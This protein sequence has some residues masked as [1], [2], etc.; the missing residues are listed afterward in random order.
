MSNTPA[1]RIPLL[2]G[3]AVDALLCGGV[4]LLAL[5]VRAWRLGDQS[6]WYDEWIT[7]RA[8]DVSGLAA[9]LR[10][11]GELDWSFVPA[12]HVL[13]YAWSEL[14]SKSDTGL[15]WLSVLLSMAAF[16]PLYALSLRL[17]GRW[18][19]A[20]ATLVF[21]LA[22]YQVFQAQSI[23]NYPLAI[24]ATIAGMYFLW[25]ATRPE[26]ARGWWMANV[27]ANGLLLW[28]HAFG[29]FLFAVQG[30]YLLLF[31]RSPVRRWFIWG[32]AHAG[33]VLSVA[34]WQ[35]TLPGNQHYPDVPP[36]P[37]SQVY[38]LL[39][40]H[41]THPFDWVDYNLPADNAREVLSPLGAWFSARNEANAFLSPRMRLGAWLFRFTALL[42]A[43]YLVSSLWRAWHDVTER[44]RLYLTAAWTLIP[45]A[46]LMALAWGLHR[47]VLVERYM[48]FAYIGLYVALGAAVARL[49][50]VWLRAGA[51][52]LLVFL[53]GAQAL[54]MQVIPLRHDYLGAARV[55]QRHAHPGEPVI[56]LKQNAAVLF[57]HNLH[58]TDHQVE[59]VTDYDTLLRRVSEELDAHGRVWV[60][61]EAVPAQVGYADIEAG[62]GERLIETFQSN[63]WA[64]SC[65]VFGGM[66]NVW[67]FKV[68]EGDGGT[69]QSE[70]GRTAY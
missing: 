41:Y 26:A 61:V 54:A 39:Q 37:L 67:L 36:P 31:R 17:Y 32:C 21:A 11:Q 42:L 22:P 47:Q 44:E 20:V 1:S 34:V 7:A 66:F 62:L 24:L 6:V 15:R 28:T 19:A 48:T 43:W 18:A 53:L 50:H 38:K 55:F 70:T 46:C 5:A 52:G 40:H 13:Q 68:G 8:V 51:A 63:G 3:R 45:L 58:D 35:W 10:V 56:A 59:Q 4:M 29:A 30:L 49:P 16:P 65:D 33:L 60:V 25:R 9:R 12:Y 14:V 57:A 27:A 64:Y 2:S 69:L 23:R